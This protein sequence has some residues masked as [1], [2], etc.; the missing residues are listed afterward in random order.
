MTEARVM[1][2]S[3]S[4]FLYFFNKEKYALIFLIACILGQISCVL[5]LN[6]DWNQMVYFF[7]SML[8]PIYQSGVAGVLFY[9]TVNTITQQKSKNIRLQRLYNNL[10]DIITELTE[11]LPRLK[12]ENFNDKSGCFSQSLKQYFNHSWEYVN[13]LTDCIVSD[14]DILLPTD[15]KAFSNIATTQSYQRVCYRQYE[16]NFKTGDIS[17]L[18]TDLRD[19]ISELEKLRDNIQKLIN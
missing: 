11:C 1:A 13:K 14:I 15:I 5:N 12:G 7:R 2:M 10:N 17:K 16:E 8:E 9:L 18:E 3:K 4:G 19:N 6:I